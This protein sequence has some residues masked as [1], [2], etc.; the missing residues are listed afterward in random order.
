M[1]RFHGLVLAGLT[2][3]LAVF[4]VGAG[5]GE[6]VE[7]TKI[8]EVTQAPEATEASTAVPAQTKEATE[9][10]AA[11]PEPTKEAT[12]A[13][14]QAATAASGTD[15]HSVGDVIDISDFILV[16][17][18]W[19]TPTSDIF[20]PDEGNK[21]VAV[22]LL[23]VKKSDSP[24]T[25]STLL[26]MSLKDSTDRQYTL[27]LVAQGAIEGG[28]LDGELAAG[29]RLRGKIGFQVPEDAAGLVFVFD[30]TLFGSGKVFIELGESPISIDPPAELA[31]ETTQETFKPGDIVDIEDFVLV[32][33]SVESSSGSDFIKPAEGS[34]FVIVDVTLENKL[35]ESV[36][37]SSLIQMSLKDATGQK[38][39]VNI[40][41]SAA[42]GAST[43][44]GEL[45][46]GEKLRGQVAFEVPSDAE[47]L[48]FV[49]DP[50]IIG[51]GRAFVAID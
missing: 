11:T 31:G 10:P 17:L 51:T 47:G 46:P 20:K 32:V 48:V 15:S 27:D 23:F 25:V 33:N 16:A 7:P 45:A 41:A 37:V 9:A 28:L 4:L 5:C 50:S 30:P 1:R 40:L 36:A 14:T 8:G 13:P 18:G 12:E 34:K 39:D 26:Q 43:P 19:E 35:D 6:Q 38:Y 21:F 2:F 3:A 24:V 44:D 29:E 42:G 22:E 49:F